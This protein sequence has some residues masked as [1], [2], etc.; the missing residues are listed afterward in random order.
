MKGKIAPSLM[1][2]DL[3]N[4]ERDIK[5]LEEAEVDYLHIDIMDNHF[6]PNVTLGFD[7]IDAIRKITHLP[8][9]IHLMIE[10]PENS[11][12]YIKNCSPKDIVSLHYESTPHIHRALAL[13]KGLGA[14]AGVA[15]NP[16]TPIQVLED[17]LPDIDVVLVMTVNPGFAGQQ[18]VPATLNKISKLRKMLDESGHGHIEIE[19]DGNVSFEKAKLMYECGADIY[20]GGSSSVFHKDSSILE[21]SQKMREIV[22]A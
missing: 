14:K 9:D 16:G 13:V 20:V 3:M 1:C 12:S 5:I 18:L 21:N 22:N 15:I 17:L 11:L 2:V 19:V 7:F 4:V 6:V 8:L 10:N